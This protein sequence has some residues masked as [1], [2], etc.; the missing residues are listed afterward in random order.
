MQYCWISYIERQHLLNNLAHVTN[1]WRKLTWVRDNNNGPRHRLPKVITNP[2]NLFVLPGIGGTWKLSIWRGRYKDNAGYTKTLGIIDVSNGDWLTIWL[3]EGLYK[4]SIWVLGNIIFGGNTEQCVTKC[5]SSIL[6][7]NVEIALQRGENYH[8]V[9]KFS[10]I[11]QLFHYF[12]IP[13]LFTDQCKVF[14]FGELFREI[15]SIFI[16]FASMLSTSKLLNDCRFIK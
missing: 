11:F 9:P 4:M 13:S 10:P 15:I 2:G 1:T 12:S 14:Y 8:I 6:S 7:T 5:E 16:F 3:T